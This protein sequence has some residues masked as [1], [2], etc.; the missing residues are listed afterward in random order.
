M[1]KMGRGAMIPFDCDHSDPTQVFVN[2]QLVARGKILV[3]GE[4][5]SLE[6]TEVVQ[7]S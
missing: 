5:M 6:I 4:M 2:N 3:E 1:L 7:R